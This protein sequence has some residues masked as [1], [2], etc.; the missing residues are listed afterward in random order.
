M[1]QTQEDLKSERE[2]GG[3]PSISATPNPSLSQ[4]ALL[5]QAD[6]GCR[7]PYD[8]SSGRRLRMQSC[9]PGG[10]DHALVQEQN[11]IGVCSRLLV[12]VCLESTGFLPGARCCQWPPSDKSPLEGGAEHRKKVA[13]VRKG[14]PDP[15]PG[16]IPPSP[17]PLTPSPP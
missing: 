16:E 14:G 5:T 4:A 10:L 12:G 1:R 8:L 15:C 13:T 3:T 9:L 11:V 17:P 7:P 6:P 2:G